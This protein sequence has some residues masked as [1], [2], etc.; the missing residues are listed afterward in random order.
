MPRPLVFLLLFAA[1]GC[2]PRSAPT[3]KVPVPTGPPAAAEPE[4]RN[5][6]TL[7]PAAAAKVRGLMKEDGYPYLRVRVDEALDQKLDLESTY[8]PVDDL[9]GE[10]G[11]VQIVV[12]RK[13][14]GM[15]ADGLTVDYVDTDGLKGF[16]FV[17][18]KRKP[19]I[20]AAT[21]PDARKGF[22]TKLARRESANEPL[23]QPPA[24]V[25]RVVRYESPAGGLAAYL[26][27]DPQDGKKHPAIV[28]VTG[29]DCNTIGEVWNDRP[30]ANDQTA[31]QFRKAGVV[32][33]FPSLRGGNQNPGVREGFLGEVDDV[34]AAAEYLRKLPYVDP[35][36]VYLGGHSTGG[37]LVLLAAAS[38][39]K[40]RA[41]FSFGPV[42][43]VAGYGPQY[44]PCDL[45]DPKELELRSP[46]RWA[47]TIRVPTFVFEGTV[48]G[49]TDSLTEMAKA[50]TNPN[51]RFFPVRG[52]NHFNL[53]APINTLIAGRVLKDTG[54]KCD[55]AF[56]EGELNRLFEK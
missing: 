37:T 39:D 32:L 47:N 27:P 3:A 56:T 14:A 1:V 7:T 54:E 13:S 36:R 43:D 45:S 33:M 38:S 55:L 35:A 20:T 48:G 23:D 4:K 11:G 29:G 8:N 16:K 5:L 9:L 42:D 53:L 31:G 21:L 34:L 44:V 12:D 28:W 17:A 22:V 15:L 24:K 30:A 51:M 2:G 10:S 50:S 18:P 52:A 40:F 6:V 26:T 46:G 19:A 41:V 49:N 25:F